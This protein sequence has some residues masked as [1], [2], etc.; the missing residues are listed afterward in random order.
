M[1]LTRYV[2]LILPGVVAGLVLVPVSASAT[3]AALPPD[4]PRPLGQSMVQWQRTYLQWVLGSSDAPPVTNVCGATIGKVY[5]VAPPT[6]PS[7]VRH[8]DVPLGKMI[9][10]SPA[11][12][13]SEIPTFGSTDAEIVADA[14][15][16]FSFLDDSGAT[17][18][19][20]SLRLGAGVSAGAYDVR[21]E[22][23]SFYDVVNEGTPDDWAPGDIVR[24]ASTA[25][26]VAIPPLTPGQHEL[27]LEASFFDGAGSLNETMVLHVG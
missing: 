4:T 8:C 1:R 14:N 17:L 24:V 19:G 6:S 22:A 11:G 26:M 25:Q 15:V 13:F 27:E 16:T 9:I 21:V 12:A 10:T 3:S 5:F 20:A 23:G 18:D 7:G 2:H